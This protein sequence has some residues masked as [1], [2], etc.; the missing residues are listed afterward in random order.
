MADVNED[1]MTAD[2]DEDY[3]VASG[4]EDWQTQTDGG[5]DTVP[6]AWQGRTPVLP[7][8][9]GRAGYPA[10]SGRLGRR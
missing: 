8:T 5:T 10:G 1:W 7:R 4:D 6:P 3:M 2:T 9:I